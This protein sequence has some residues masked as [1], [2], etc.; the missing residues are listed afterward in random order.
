LG[1]WCSLFS[2]LC[3]ISWP[4]FVFLSLFCWPLYCLSFEFTRVGGRMYSMHVCTLYVFCMAK[5]I[6]L[7]NF[8]DIEHSWNSMFWNPVP[9]IYW[10]LTPTLA[11]FQLYL[12]L[13]SSFMQQLKWCYLGI[14]IL[15]NFGKNRWRNEFDRVHTCIEYIRPPTRVNSKDRQYEL[16]VQKLWH[17]AIG[18]K[19]H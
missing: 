10:C 16:E 13:K 8:E 12:G 18:L 2:F 4:L 9:L 19:K 17:W 14:N 15:C 6:D 11:V 5:N 1:W 7:R 3:N